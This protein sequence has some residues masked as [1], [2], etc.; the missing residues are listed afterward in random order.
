MIILNSSIIRTGITLKKRFIFDETYI[1]KYAKKGKLK[2]LIIG[3][4]SLVLIIVIIIIILAT[5][6][7]P[8]E[9]IEPVEPTYTLKEELTI[10]SGSPL[11]EVS[12]YFDELENIDLNSIIITY[13]D[14]FELSYDTSLCSEE[15]VEEIYSEEEPNYDG[16]DCVQN[17]LIT[18]ATYGVTIEIEGEEYT[19]NL[20]VEDTSAPSVVTKDLEIYDGDVYEAT[21][22]IDACYDATSDCIIEFYAEDTDEEDNPID[23][24]NI[25]EV[26]EHTVKI[27][28]KDDYDNATDPI[29][30][31]LTIL[32][33]EG[34]MYTVTFNSDGGSEVKRKRVAENG[35]V[36]EPT[37]PT[38]EGYNFLGWYLNDAEFDFNTKITSDITLVAKWEEISAENPGGGNGGG[39]TSVG[40][41]ISS[42]SLNYKTIYL[43][44]GQT[45]TV[46]A[47]VNPANSSITWTSSNTAVATVS[48]GN[49]TGVGN[50]TAT[51]TATAN[52]KSASVEVIVSGSGSGSSCSYGNTTYNT[53]YVLSVNLTQNGCA[54]NPNSTPNETLSTSDYQRLVNELSSMG[55]RIAGNNFSHQV[56]RQKIRNTSGTGLVGYQLTISV[57]IIDSDNPYV[58]MQARYILRSDGSR[59]FIT[60]NICKNNVCLS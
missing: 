1:K 23:Y 31:K 8:T 6:D 26:G 20:N 36:I 11:P 19:V 24:S 13:P 49:I 43:S 57:G 22:F 5:R 56:D 41:I 4:S 55:L 12:D 39:G 29:E 34:N 50:G 60:N 3:S 18:P 53:S 59:Q 48:N 15:E 30:V 32:E 35:S 54:I 9:P 21:D 47:Y 33:V 44:P 51:I 16:Y 45:K 25:V 28:A 40:P 17:I 46:T 52:G 7:E 42:I 2:W 38:K 10:E 14:E 37:E 58:V 27:I